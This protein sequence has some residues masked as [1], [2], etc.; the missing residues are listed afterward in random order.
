MGDR[1]TD[2]QDSEQTTARGRTR[3]C[4]AMADRRGRVFV[5]AACLAWSPALIGCSSSASNQWLADMFHGSHDSS[6]PVRTAGPP[7]ASITSAQA[8]RPVVAGP[9]LMG[10]ASAGTVLAGMPPPGFVPPTSPAAPL[11]PTIAPTAAAAPAPAAAS[12]E[13]D[14][15]ASAYPSVALFDIFRRDAQQAAHPTGPPILSDS[16]TPATRATAT[17]QPAPPASSSSASAAAPAASTSSDDYDAAASAY[18]SV[19]LFDIFRHAS[20]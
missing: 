3:V 9:P 17:G 14:A 4:C 18:P 19:P 10:T 7:P 12:D 6:P 20:N 13:F 2:G 11:P 8:V 16:V 1:V 5:L 15:A